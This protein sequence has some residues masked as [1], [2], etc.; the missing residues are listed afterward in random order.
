M[1][2]TSKRPRREEETGTGDS[3]SEVAGRPDSPREKAVGYSGPSLHLA[4]LPHRAASRRNILAV[5][6]SVGQ[7]SNTRGVE[8][9]E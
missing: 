6:Q 7:R 4:P 1:L 5:G 2:R 3:D 8:W 9:S